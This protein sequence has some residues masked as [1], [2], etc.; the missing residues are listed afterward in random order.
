MPSLFL[1]EYLFLSRYY[2]EFQPRDTWHCLVELDVTCTLHLSLIY[3]ERQRI[4]L[5]KLRFRVGRGSAIF[6]KE[7][8][9]RLHAKCCTQSL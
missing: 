2:R 6:A 4:L 8:S 7:S 3:A 5:Y 9:E 1:A